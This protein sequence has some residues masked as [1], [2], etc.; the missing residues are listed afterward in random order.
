M[1]LYSGH[2]QK[3]ENV[4]TNIIKMDDVHRFAA[5]AT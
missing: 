4:T 5:P 1:R 2:W 3:K